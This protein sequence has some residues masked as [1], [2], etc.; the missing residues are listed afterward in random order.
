M[1][2]EFFSLI[3]H[4]VGKKILIYAVKSL[5]THLSSVSPKFTRTINYN[6]TLAEVLL[7]DEDVVPRVDGS[8]DKR[9]SVQN[10]I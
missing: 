2:N 6:I 10:R 3:I 4:Y 5:F 1:N 7:F 8:N 9:Q